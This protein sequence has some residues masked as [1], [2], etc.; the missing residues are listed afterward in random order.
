MK[1]IVKNGLTKELLVEL[2]Y[3]DLSNITIGQFANEFYD[4]LSQI[5]QYSI[6]PKIES[7]KYLIRTNVIPEDFIF[8]WH[9][10]RFTSAD[11]VFGFNNSNRLLNSCIK[12][13]LN[14]CIVYTLLSVY[15]KNNYCFNQEIHVV[16]LDKQ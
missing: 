2:N 9:G 1:I 4:K 12:S 14:E 13:E 15:G 3:D 10:Y 11:S 5:Y 7:E 8:Y 6:I 16:K